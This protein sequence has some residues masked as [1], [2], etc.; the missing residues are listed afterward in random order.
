MITI[1]NYSFD[2]N[3]EKPKFRY[4]VFVR[5]CQT[6]RFPSSHVIHET[7]FSYV[8]QQI[9]RSCSNQSPTNFRR[10]P[11]DLQSSSI[12][13]FR[14]PLE[15]KSDPSFD[16]MRL[17][18]TA[19]TARTRSDIVQPGKSANS[20]RKFDRLAMAKGTKINPA[21]T[22]H[23]RHH[24]DHRSAR[25]ALIGRLDEEETITSSKINSTV[26]DIRFRS[27]I[28][29]FAEVH[30]T[31]EIPK[32]SVETIVQSNSSLHD[33]EGRWKTMNNRATI[34]EKAQLKQRRQM[35]IKQLHK[36]IDIFLIEVGA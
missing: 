34:A 13:S 4:Q 31:K 24:R 18:Q 25:R 5:K 36:N 35:L 9:L 17:N 19:Q 15:S 10:D 30:Q 16:R 33:D 21:G 6:S 7:I 23:I 20:Q 3:C 28:G 14:L 11:S 2:N 29:T 12:S 1:K 8:E 27:L 26:D 22:A 32:K